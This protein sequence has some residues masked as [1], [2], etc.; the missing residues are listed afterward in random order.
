MR[1]GGVVLSQL[2]LQSERASDQ[3]EKR[4]VA[5]FHILSLVA[6]GERNAEYPVVMLWA[7]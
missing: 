7:I 1:G 6:I 5:R 2:R 4:T 3:L